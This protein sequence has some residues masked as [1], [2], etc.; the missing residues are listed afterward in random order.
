MVESEPKGSESP[1]RAEPERL[2][3]PRQRAGRRTKR[4]P[5]SERRRVVVPRW[6]SPALHFFALFATA[7]VSLAILWRD[8]PLGEVR[9]WAWLAIPLALVM[10]NALEYMVHRFPMHKRNKRYDRLFVRHT[11]SHHRWFTHK[12][13]PIV[14]LK[15]LYMVFFQVEVVFVVLAI[16]AVSSV[17]A[18]LTVGADVGAVFCS[19]LIGYW[20]A[21][22]LVHAATHLPNHWYLR[23]PLRG[24]IL[25]YLRAFHRAHHDPRLMTKGNFNV[26]F[27]LMDHLFGTV[28]P[29]VYED[30]ELEPGWVD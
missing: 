3:S 18:N 5:L 20:L 1:P 15:E 14:V 21:L 16:V 9:P 4:D 7:V 6:Y 25:R 19:S 24:P 27:P 28:V 17:T 23:W 13:M 22:E 11:L 26:T 30:P 29:G 2:T 10:A 12:R 8:V